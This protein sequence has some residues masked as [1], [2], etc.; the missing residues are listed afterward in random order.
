[1]VSVAVFL[2]GEDFSN[3]HCAGGICREDFGD[4][5]DCKEDRFGEI[6]EFWDSGGG[7]WGAKRDAILAYPAPHHFVPCV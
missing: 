7:F 4:F 1:M 3:F 2:V 6:H 5:H